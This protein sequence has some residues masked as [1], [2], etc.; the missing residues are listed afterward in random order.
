MIDSETGS[1]VPDVRF[2]HL[3][4]LIFFSFVLCSL[5]LFRCSVRRCLSPFRPA[6]APFGLDFTSLVCNFMAPLCQT[7]MSELAVH[8]APMVKTAF[9]CVCV[10]LD[11]AQKHTE[12]TYSQSDVKM[13]CTVFVF[14]L[15]LPGPNLISCHHCLFLRAHRFQTMKEKFM[16]L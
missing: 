7:K 4:V 3:L 11:L 13:L 8:H 2:Q 9:L 14:H 12:T 16:Q 15:S 10:C 5:M 6:P 1:V